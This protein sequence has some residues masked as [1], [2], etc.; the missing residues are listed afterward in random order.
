V[1][2]WCQP[3]NSWIAGSCPAGSRCAYLSTSATDDQPPSIF[4]A[5]KSR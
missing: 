2:A 4:S 3:K 5:S 1:P